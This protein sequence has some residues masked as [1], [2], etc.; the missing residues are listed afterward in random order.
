MGN[1]KYSCL[2]ANMQPNES[3][4]WLNKLTI[5]CQIVLYYH[6]CILEIWNESQLTMDTTFSTRTIKQ[7]LTKWEK[8]TKGSL[9]AQ[10]PQHIHLK[11]FKYYLNTIINC[12]IHRRQ[13]Q[14]WPNCLIEQRNS[15]LYQCASHSQSFHVKLWLKAPLATCSHHI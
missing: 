6:I 11:T 5:S 3:V 9:L 14:T 10:H 15:Q 8:Q 4:I 12:E 1:L 13:A 2:G 7:L